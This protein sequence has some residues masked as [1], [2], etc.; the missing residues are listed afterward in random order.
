M[1]IHARASGNVGHSCR[2]MSA[3]SSWLAVC[4]SLLGPAVVPERRPPI[5]ERT[6]MKLGIVWSLSVKTPHT[7]QPPLHQW[8][9]HPLKLALRWCVFTNWCRRFDRLHTLYYFLDYTHEGCTCFFLFISQ[10][11]AGSVEVAVLSSDCCSKA[12]DGG[13]AVRMLGVCVSLK[14]CSIWLKY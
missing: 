1:L 5:A 7:L 6:D 8:H 3:L 9:G 10:P 11:A 14:C 12:P 13:C 2:M 4:R